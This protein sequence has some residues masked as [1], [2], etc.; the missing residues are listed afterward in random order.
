MIDGFVTGDSEV[1]A[2]LNGFST[3]VGANLKSA[4][5]R[6]TIQLQNKAKNEKL[7]GQVLNVRTGRLKRSIQQT[8]MVSG[9]SVV[10]V[11]STNVAYAPPHEYGFSGTVSVKQSLRTVKQAFGRPIAARQVSVRSHQRKVNLPERSFLRSALRE[12]NES[13]VIVEVIT[14]AVQK[15]K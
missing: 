4:I 13:G 10:G 2:N 8:V 12:M 5:T 9:S 6:L 7:S 14:Q 15:G 3:S 11:V 1:I